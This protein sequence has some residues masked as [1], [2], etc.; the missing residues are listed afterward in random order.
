MKASMHGISLETIGEE[1]S[2]YNFDLDPTALDYD[3]ELG[4]HFL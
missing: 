1:S 2:P 3:L 4:E